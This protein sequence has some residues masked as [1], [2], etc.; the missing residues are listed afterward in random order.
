LLAKERVFCHEFG[1]ASEKVCQRPHHERGGSVR[2]GPG[3]EAMAERLK[4]KICQ[5]FDEDM[6]PMHSV[7]Y[8]F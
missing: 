1:L 5:S 7:P 4:A 3:S 6:N 2:F 8:P